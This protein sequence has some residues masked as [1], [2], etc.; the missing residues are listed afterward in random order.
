MNNNQ[1]TEPVDENQIVDEDKTIKHNLIPILIN[2]K[3]L[4]KYFGLKQSTISKMVMHGQFTNIVKVGTKNFFKT[5]DV[6][7]WIDD[8]TIEVA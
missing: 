4:E 1:T 7:A 5:K 3:G 2:Y 6:M 8:N